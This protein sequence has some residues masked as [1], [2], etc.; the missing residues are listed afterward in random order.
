[1]RD[2]IIDVAQRG[3]G[4]TLD[5]SRV[6]RTTAA[7]ANAEQQYGANMQSGELNARVRAALD[8]LTQVPDTSIAAETANSR[9]VHD[10]L[11]ACRDLITRVGNQSNL[12][13]DPDLDSY[14]SMSLS[15][16]RYPRCST[17]WTASAI[18]CTKART[19]RSG[20]A[21]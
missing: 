21:N 12:I 6:A 7:L 10:A 15:I 5:A 18:V 19:M 8:A 1:V 3:A 4:G 13:L 14:Y 9:A 16:L 20:G 2:A 17:P 11:S